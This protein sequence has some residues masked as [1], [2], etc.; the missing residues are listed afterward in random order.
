MPFAF[1]LKELKKG[2]FPHYFN[3]EANQNYLGP[4]PPAPFYNPDDMT[5]SAKAAFYEWY[6]K[7][8]G[9]FDFQHQFLTYCK[10]DVDILQRSLLNLHRP[11]KLW[12][13]WSLSKKLSRLLVLPI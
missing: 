8:Q 11:S 3:T 12:L 13:K 1:G 6:E 9:V 5:S 7:Q 2:Y 10:S 4:Y